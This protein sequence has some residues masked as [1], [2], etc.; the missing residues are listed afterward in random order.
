MCVGQP[1]R[2][3]C[4]GDDC[5]GPA[6]ARTV[7]R[8]R[9]SHSGDRSGT[10]PEQRRGGRAGRQPWPERTHRTRRQEHLAHSV[11]AVHGGDGAHPD[12]RC[13]AL[14]RARQVPRSRRHRGH[15]GPVR[16]AGLLPGI[17][18][19]EGDC[20]AQE[21]GRAGRAGTARR[22]PGEHFGARP[23][24]WRPRSSRGRQRRAC[25]CAAGRRGQSAHPGIAAH[26]RIGARGETGGAARHGGPAAWRPP[27]HGLPRHAGHLRAR[28]GDCRRDRP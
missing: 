9:R 22:P 20:R 21:A 16:P 1:C 28:A 13:P 19:R 27:Q 7:G 11:G 3:H 23:R 10:R 8:R 12:R 15:R 26:R 4:T 17:P 14:A 24:A 6:L 18:R 25:R 5:R 2:R